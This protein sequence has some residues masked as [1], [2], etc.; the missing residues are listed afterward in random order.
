VNVL[1][2]ELGSSWFFWL[3]SDPF[4]HAPGVIHC[5]CAELACKWQLLRYGIGTGGW[6]AGRM[7]A[8]LQSGQLHAVFMKLSV[9]CS[10]CY[11]HAAIV[12]CFHNCLFFPACWRN[13]ACRVFF[14]DE[15]LAT[16]SGCGCCWGL[17]SD[18][19]Q[20]VEV[21]TFLF[22]PAGRFGVV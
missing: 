15:M 12:I 4:V 22:D 1:D 3:V 11:L 20:I 19:Y 13:C 8:R 16:G 9:G 6:P 14:S 7:C 17:L 10:S 5:A 21:A 18:Y 2:F